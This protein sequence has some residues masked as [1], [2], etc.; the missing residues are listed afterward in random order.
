MEMEGD[1]A[2]MIMFPWQTSLSPEMKYWIKRFENNEDGLKSQE[3][4][5]F[6]TA[7]EIYA[8][9][10]PVLPA[11]IKLGFSCI[12][13][14]KRVDQLSKSTASAEQFT[15]IC[16]VHV[17]DARVYE[18]AVHLYFDHVRIYGKKKEF[19]AIERTEAELLFNRIKGNIPWDKKSWNGWCNALKTATPK[20]LLTMSSMRHSAQSTPL[21]AQLPDT[22]VKSKEIMESNYSVSDQQS[23]TKGV[24]ADHQFHLLLKENEHLKDEIREQDVLVSHLS[25]EAG[26]YKLVMSRKNMFKL[27]RNEIKLKTK[28]LKYKI[29]ELAFLVE[30]VKACA[31]TVNNADLDEN[32][33]EAFKKKIL[34]LAEG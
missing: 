32:T 17:P 30:S 26:K 21:T 11:L 15:L 7:G 24:N 5:C 19:F 20:S 10:T 28:K 6:G 9:A 14:E 8:A 2:S 12:S 33:A 27:E 22:N 31:N 25:N 18:K 23:P 4:V 16:S 3:T 29:K 34:A 1:N 13:A